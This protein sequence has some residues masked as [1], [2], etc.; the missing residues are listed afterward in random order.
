QVKVKSFHKLTMENYQK[1]IMKVN[2]TKTV[3]K[4]DGMIFIE[5]NMDYNNTQ[6]LKWKPPEFLT[7]DFWAIRYKPDTYILSVG[8]STK[9]ANEFGIEPSQEY[10]KLYADT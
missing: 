7:I 6:N 2:T 9:M 5:S 4:Q 1:C 3:Y 10:K 8:I